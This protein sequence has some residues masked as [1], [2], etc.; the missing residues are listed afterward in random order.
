MHDQRKPTLDE[1]TEQM[2]A[3]RM[4]EVRED[5]K[6]SQAALAQKLASEYGITLDASAITRI[7]QRRQPFESMSANE[8]AKGSTGRAIRLGEAAAI[9]AALETT[10]D[11]LLEP[12]HPLL[13]QRLAM[14]G[15][16]VEQS[17]RAFQSA[18]HDYQTAQMQLAR[19]QEELHDGVS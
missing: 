17:K 9:A 3:S 14:L 16:R 15:E 4:R 11:A 19:V 8:Q 18:Q 13:R 7:E 5:R 10:L 2:F 12:D 1:Q 6:L